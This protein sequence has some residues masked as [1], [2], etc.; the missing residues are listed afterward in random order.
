MKRLSLFF[1]LTLL[2]FS[3]KNND[4]EDK[5]LTLHQLACEN[6]KHNLDI[7]LDNNFTVIRSKEAYDHQVTGNCHPEIDFNLYDLVIGKQSL[8][9][10]NDTITYNLKRQC[11]DNKLKLT[12]DMLQTD[13]AKPDIVVYHAL[14]PKLGD[15][16][17]LSLEINV[18][19]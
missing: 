7:G 16:E 11:S 14:I 13:A 12:I 4:C 2:A 5:V 8:S 3:C 6:S 15:E 1:I 10:E 19:N 18:K 17:G 9:T